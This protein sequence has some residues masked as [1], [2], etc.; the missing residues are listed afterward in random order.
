MKINN[1][2]KQLEAEMFAGIVV[3]FQ[4]LQY[5]QTKDLSRCLIAI[6]QLEREYTKITKNT[7]IKA[8]T[9][10]RLEDGLRNLLGAKSVV[11]KA[12]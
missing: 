12:K 4:C 10:K 8:D 3:S 6:N 2:S 5:K 9:R 11:A 7:F 1:D